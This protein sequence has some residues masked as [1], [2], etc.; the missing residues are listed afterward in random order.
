MSSFDA[1]ET[2]I[3]ATCERWPGFPREPAVLVRLVKVIYK[4]VHDRANGVLR[5]HDLSH[6]EYNILMML[7]GTPAR[8]LNPSELAEAATEKS[9]NIT[10]LTDQLCGKGL[11]ER[12][13]DTTDRRKLGLN[14]TKAGLRCVEGVLPKMAELL[15]EQVQGLDTKEQ[16]QLERLLKKMLDGFDVG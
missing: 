6:A 12:I 14:L 13:P 16:H 7:Y 2:R 4:A 1:T 9:A 11:V 5:E 15:V 3:D 8:A 10:R